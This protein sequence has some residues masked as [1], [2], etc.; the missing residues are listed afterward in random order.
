MGWWPK[1][2]DGQRLSAAEKAILAL[3]AAIIP[4]I[5]AGLIVWAIQRWLSGP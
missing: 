1:R 4:L 3:I 5:I 2:W